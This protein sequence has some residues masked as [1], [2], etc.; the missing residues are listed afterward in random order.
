MS[1]LRSGLLGDVLIDFHRHDNDKAMVLHALFPEKE[2]LNQ[3]AMWLGAATRA[4]IK[5]KTWQWVVG[6]AP[7][8]RS[9]IVSYRYNDGQG[10]YVDIVK[11]VINVVSCH[12]AA[13][14]LVSTVVFPYI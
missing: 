4:K 5:E 10:N 6:S 12:V 2:S 9:L 13:D 14:K 1:H 3:H 8:T 11:D 7:P